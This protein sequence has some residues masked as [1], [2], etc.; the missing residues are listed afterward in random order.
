MLLRNTGEALLRGH[1]KSTYPKYDLF[2]LLQRVN[3]KVLH[4][5][6]LQLLK[7][8]NIPVNI[9]DSSDFSYRIILSTEVDDF[10]G[11]EKIPSYTH[12]EMEQIIKEGC[13]ECQQLH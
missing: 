11:S 7:S 8:Y 3:L 2:E 9:L 12:D 13:F 10:F 1:T 4:Q 6:W 5:Q